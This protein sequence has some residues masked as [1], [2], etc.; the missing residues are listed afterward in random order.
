[1]AP[2]IPADL[3]DAIEGAPDDE[4]ALLEVRLQWSGLDDAQARIAAR[5]RVFLLTW[6]PLGWH[7]PSRGRATATGNG[8]DCE[9]VLYLPLEQILATTDAGEELAVVVGSFAASV[10]SVGAA[11]E[12]AL[13]AGVYPQLAFEGKAP[14]LLSEA[15]T[16]TGLAPP[17][18]ALASAGWEPIGLG[19]IQD[20]VQEEFGPV[21]LDRS[22]VRLEAVDDAVADCPA[23]AG[24]RF[25]FPAELSDA[26][27]A[28]CTPHAE[29]A[30][31]VTDERLQRAWESNRDGMD[32]ISGCSELLTEP[33][34]G[35]TLA[36]LRR[37]D[38]I[39]RR[40]PAESLSSAE[41]AADAELV[42]ALAARLSGEPEQVAELMAYDYLSVEWMVELPMALASGG[43]VDEAIAVG[44][45]FAALDPSN[46]DMFASDVALILA[47]AG[48]GAE[49]LRRALTTTSRPA[50]A[51]PGRTSAPP[52]STP[53]WATRHR[54]RLRCGPRSCWRAAAA[55]PT[56]SPPS[57]CASARCWTSSPVARTRPATRCRNPS[58]GA[59]RRMAGR[60]S[61]RRSGATTPVRVAAAAS[62]S[63]AA[64][65]DGSRRS[66][67]GETDPVGGLGHPTV[68]RDDLGQRGAERSGCG[69]MDRIQAAQRD[70]AQRGGLVE[71]HVVKP[72]QRD[73]LKQLPRPAG[74]LL[75]MDANDADHLD[76]R[77]RT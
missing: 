77:E 36:L 75:T 72:H 74:C 1:M 73:P 57:G 40:D 51:A 53:S 46:E 70:R 10:L 50:R 60:G 6:D 55:T 34:F 48:R 12:Q 4:R 63:A 71:E 27:P 59:M 68:V 38:E 58:A 45:A 20:L 61:W 49:A 15:G 64:A 37:L 47:E 21:A 56:T 29:Q 67:H 54:R 33:T 7:E 66:D 44:D 65:P 14:G 19:A 23:C 76:A 8:D 9:V 42:V 69:E 30:G 25:G 41:L 52:P 24:R 17:A 62:T 3:R 13:V 26:Q 18:L 11:Y 32:A 39:A 31:A 22:P 5:L 28:I 16:L 35:L 43:L 2:G